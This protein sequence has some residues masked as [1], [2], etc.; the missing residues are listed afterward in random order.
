MAL[1]ETTTIYVGY[2]ELLL[3]VRSSILLVYAMEYT[4]F[5]TMIMTLL[6]SNKSTY[7]RLS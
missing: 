6:F 2:M 4:T 7:V 5:T 3:A 1:Q